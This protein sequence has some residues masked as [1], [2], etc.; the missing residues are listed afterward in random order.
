[1]F[2]LYEDSMRADAHRLLPEFTSP[3]QD[4]RL[5][6]SSV[7]PGIRLASRKTC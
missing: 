6:P 7:T 2:D 5:Y 1:M 3:Y 4:F